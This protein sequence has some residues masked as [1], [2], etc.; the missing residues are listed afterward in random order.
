MTQYDLVPEVIY[1]SLEKKMGEMIK[2]MISPTYYRQL[3]LTRENKEL[4]MKTHE[5]DM[6]LRDLQLLIKKDTNIKD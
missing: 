3:D 5:F 4:Y 6:R 1:N 2:S